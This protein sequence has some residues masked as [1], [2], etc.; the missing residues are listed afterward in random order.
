MSDHDLPRTSVV[1]EQTGVP[2]CCLACGESFLRREAATPE[3][4]RLACPSCGGTEI[5][6]E[7]STGR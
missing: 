6:Q 7:H 3:K 4:G 5:E 1:P 2:M